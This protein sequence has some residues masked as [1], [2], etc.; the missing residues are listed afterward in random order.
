L[1]SPREPSIA[2][3]DNCRA[4]H[5]RRAL[6]RRLHRRIG[7]GAAVLGGIVAAPLGPA[8]LCL[9]RLRPVNGYA[10]YNDT[11]SRPQWAARVVTGAPPALRSVGQPDGL[12]PA[13]VLLPVLIAAEVSNSKPGAAQ[14]RRVSIFTGKNIRGSVRDRMCCRSE[15]VGQQSSASPFGLLILPSAA[16]VSMPALPSIFSR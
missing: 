12:E 13:Q 16:R 8:R 1:L 10:A 7:V 3:A 15:A 5:G 6:P 4:D 9:W 14:G 2:A 11:T